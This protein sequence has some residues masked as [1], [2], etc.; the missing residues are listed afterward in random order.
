MTLANQLVSRWLDDGIAVD[1]G[2]S[3]AVVDDFQQTHNVTLPDDFLDYLLA[4]NGMG[5]PFVCDDNMFSF[6][7]IQQIESIVDHFPDRTIGVR[8]AQRYFMFADHSISLPT[9]AIKLSNDKSAPTPIATVFF[10]FGA[11]DLE[12]FCDSFTEFVKLY[13]DNPAHLSACLPTATTERVR[14]GT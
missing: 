3:P 11:F 10:D 13:L 6:W 4:V 14:K 2:V 8:D 1:S 7:P 5:E 9:Y 12:D